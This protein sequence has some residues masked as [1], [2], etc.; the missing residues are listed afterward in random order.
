M[1][2]LF[3]KRLNKVLPD[4]IQ[5]DQKTDFDNNKRRL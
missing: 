5:L 3:K 1:W 4:N 2:N